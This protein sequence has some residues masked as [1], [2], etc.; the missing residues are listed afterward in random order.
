MRHT[1]HVE[2]G[3]GGHCILWRSD[4]LIKP[5]VAHRQKLKQQMTL[6]GVVNDIYDDLCGQLDALGNA[7]VIAIDLTRPNSFN[8][9]APLPA[10]SN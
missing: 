6:H 3:R 8:H 10:F 4:G 1:W 2:E 5:Q 9:I 7:T